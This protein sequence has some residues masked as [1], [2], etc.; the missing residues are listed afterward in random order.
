MQI[1]K[2]YDWKYKARKLHGGIAAIRCVGIEF[3]ME[4]GENIVAKVLFKSNYR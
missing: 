4:I 3:Y 1:L 2:I